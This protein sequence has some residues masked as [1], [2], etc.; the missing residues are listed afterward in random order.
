MSLMG[1]GGGG[2]MIVAFSFSL[3]L[4]LPPLRTHGDK[5]VLALVDV[6]SFRCED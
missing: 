1:I 3:L 2:V 6:C 5:Y 4:W